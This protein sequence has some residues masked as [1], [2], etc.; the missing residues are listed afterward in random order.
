VFTHRRIAEQLRP[1]M[2]TFHLFREQAE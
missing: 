1:E 2:D